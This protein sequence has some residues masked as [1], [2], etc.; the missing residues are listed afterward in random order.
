MLPN[1]KRSRRLHRARPGVLVIGLVVAAACSPSRSATPAAPATKVDPPARTEPSAAPLDPALLGELVPN[2]EFTDGARGWT[3]V[4]ATSQADLGPDDGPAVALKPPSGAAAES[5][6]VPSATVSVTVPAP[7]GHPVRFALAVQ[8]LTDDS[9]LGVGFAPLRADGYEVSNPVWEEQRIEPGTWRRHVWRYTVPAGTVSL[10]VS[11]GQRPGHQALVARASLMVE[12]YELDALDAPGV[13]RLTELIEPDVERLRGMLF[14]TK[15]PV[16]V[17][18]DAQARAFFE[19]RVTDFWPVE[20][21]EAD[22]TAY[23]QLGLWP[24]EQSMVDA[25]LDLMEEQAGGFY[26]PKT[27]AFYVLGDMP[28][29]AA[30]I[31]IAHELTHA[32]DDQY[33]D[34]DGQIEALLDDTDRAAAYGAVVEGSGTVIMTRYM[35]DMIDEDV[36]SLTSLGEMQAN[37]AV[38]GEALANAP[39]YLSRSLL[40]SYVMGMHF[41]LEGKGALAIGDLD[42]AE[43]DRAFRDS[44]QSSEQILH[45]ER[46]WVEKDEPRP[47]TLPDLSA[48]LGPGWSLRRGDS[49]GEMLLP[50][51]TGGGRIDTKSAEM[52][53]PS[54]WTGLPTVGWGGDRW[55]L[56]EAPAAGAAG[57]THGGKR[58]VTLLATLWETD[59]DAQEFE[60]A[61]TAPE[62][63]HVERRGPAVVIVAGAEGQPDVET[64]ALAGAAL[65][66]IAPR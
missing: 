63:S 27:D 24:T 43:I 61:L 9:W 31:I 8:G 19:E 14:K 62:G 60:D 36:I 2:P 47:V 3:L 21:Q 54:A 13:T 52:M 37:E 28:R 46:Y 44:P 15:V 50:L 23:R 20:R 5:G 16:Q 4:E 10:K 26:D 40:F 38:Q 42:P 7:A 25:I 12:D 30:P 32:L 59:Q 55:Q 49:M 1:P 58:Y 33:Y 35:S 53:S 45:P 51:L 11:I 66:A 17:V 18:D 22:E 57:G 64:A 56:Y 34:L 6:D 39:A 65:D 48:T 29:S 41:L